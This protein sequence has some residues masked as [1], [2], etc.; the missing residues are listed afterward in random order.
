M[1]KK[2]TDFFQSVKGAGIF[3][4]LVFV[5]AKFLLPKQAVD[6]WGLIVPSKIAWVLFAL[7]ML[8]VFTFLGIRFFGDRLGRVLSGFLGGLMSSTATTVSLARESKEDSQVSTTLLVVTMLSSILAMLIEAIIFVFAGG[9]EVFDD[10][11][12]ILLVPSIFCLSVVVFFLGKNKGPQKTSNQ[13]QKTIIEY[14]SAV[15]L[16]AVIILILAVSKI[17][18]QFFGESSVRFLT[19]VVSLFEVHGSLIASTQRVATGQIVESEFQVLVAL[20]VAAS[21]FSKIG[22]AFFLGSLRFALKTLMAMAV[23]MLAIAVGFLL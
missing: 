2:M 8:Q 13:S 22:I 3:L 5:G 1:K 14:Q 15:N 19:F 20:S 18:Q 11:Q 21:L 9:Y 10:V 16:T 7:S 6:P 23:L 4:L 12:W 17:F